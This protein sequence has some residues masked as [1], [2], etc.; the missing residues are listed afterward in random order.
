M[1]DMSDLS[2]PSSCQQKFAATTNCLTCGVVVDALVI[3]GDI[4]FCP[5]DRTCRHHAECAVEGARYVDRL[6][7]GTGLKSRLLGRLDSQPLPLPLPPK[8]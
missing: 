3:L 7:Q 8:D 5:L 2:L 1:I 4:A 6:P